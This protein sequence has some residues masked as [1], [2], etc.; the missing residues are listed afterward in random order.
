[1][2]LFKL[3]PLQSRFAA[4]L[5]AS[6]VLLLLY[7]TLTKPHFA[8]AHDLSSI[9]SEDHNHYLLFDDGEFTETEDERTFIPR[10]EDGV[11]ALANNDPQNKNIDTG[12]IQSWTFPK[13]AIDGPHGDPGTGL[14][15]EK[16]DD[17]QLEPEVHELLKRQ[18]GT[19][20]YI[21]LNT[22]LQPSSN[23]SD[24]IPPQLEMYIS[25]SSSNQKPGPGSG[26]SISVTGGY[27][28]YQVLAT[29]DVFVSVGAPNVTE[30]SGSWNYEIAASNDAP[31]HSF[32]D[33]AVP[34]LYFVD[35]DNHAALLITNNLTQALPNETVY[36]EWMALSPPYGVFAT[37]QNQRSVMGV[38]KSYCGLKNNAKLSANINNISNENVAA[39][40][41]RGLGGEPKEQLYVTGLNA[42]SQYWGML[43]MNGNST[44][45]GPGVVGGG[46]TVW[47]AIDFGTKT[48]NNCALIVQP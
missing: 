27:G 4:C 25:L 13:D 11:F 26:T 16:A 31:Y 18:S 42:T 20:I 3:S 48:E 46:G 19:R 43:V 7:L 17:T 35:S 34:N 29:D 45:T 9:A 39:M 8:Y 37:N 5:S 28:L 2:P 33:P 6:A 32:L 24:D 44:A 12:S 47:A 1:M 41:N 30:F 40:T 15:N 21:T 14:P 36:Q 22:C 23:S 10:A 38:H